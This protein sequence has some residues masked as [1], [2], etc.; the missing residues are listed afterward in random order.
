MSAT[1]IARFLTPEEVSAEV[2]GGAVAP[3][4]IL[5]LSKAQGLPSHRVGRRRMYLAEEVAA[6]ARNRDGEGGI[7]PAASPPGVGPDAP[8]VDPEWVAAQLSKFSADDLRRAGNLLLA[9]S[10]QP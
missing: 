8:S 5:K 1:T 3:D 4:R 2:F 6:W 7:D 10:G 9:L